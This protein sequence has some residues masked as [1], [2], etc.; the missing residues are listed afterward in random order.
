MKEDYDSPTAKNP[1]HASDMART[2]RT[3]YFAA[4]AEA[5]GVREE[6]LTLPDSVETV[7]DFS[8][9][10]AASRAALKG[11]LETVRFALNESFADASTRI[12]DGDV[13]AVIPPVSGG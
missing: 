5:L 13:I 12:R 9:W 6:S 7:G 4:I 11:R 10:L 1:R 8:K 2:V 3:L